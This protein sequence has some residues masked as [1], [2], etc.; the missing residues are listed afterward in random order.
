MARLTIVGNSLG[1][2]ATKS[3]AEGD[4]VAFSAF[5]SNVW[6]APN[7][8]WFNSRIYGF[9]QGSNERMRERFLLNLLLECVYCISIA[10]S[11]ASIAGIFIYRKDILDAF[12][13]TGFSLFTIIANFFLLILTS[14]LWGF[15]VSNNFISTEALMEFTAR[16]EFLYKPIRFVIN[17]LIRKYISF[18]KN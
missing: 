3:V 6:T 13:W 11:Y 5:F 14:K 8:V 2:L 16:K 17:F 12:L 10:F 4:N 9:C 18:V 7:F 15:C 1:A